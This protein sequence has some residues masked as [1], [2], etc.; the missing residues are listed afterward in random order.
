MVR[1]LRH[2]YGWS[3]QS[4]ADRL[5]G[6]GFPQLNRSVL[7]NIESGRRKQGVTVDELVALAHAF[8]VRPADLLP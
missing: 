2:R 1:D 6:I 8:E 5:A 4:L 3:A 7:A